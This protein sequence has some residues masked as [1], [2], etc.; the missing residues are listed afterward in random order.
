MR[1]TS[2]PARRHGSHGKLENRVNI[3]RSL[4]AEFARIQRIAAT[5]RNSGEFRYDGI[6]GT[7]RPS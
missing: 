3:V 2:A 1:A 4:V 6:G 7:V 5:L